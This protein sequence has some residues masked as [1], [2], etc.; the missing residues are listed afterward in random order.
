MSLQGKPGRA[1]VS[2]TTPS[3]AGTRK[4]S[5]RQSAPQATGVCTTL[6]ASSVSVPLSATT[7]SHLEANS[8]SVSATVECRPPLKE[9]TLGDRS[10]TCV[11]CIPITE[12]SQTS[13]QASTSAGKGFSLSW[14]S[15]ARAGS[16]NLWLPTETD[17]V[18]LHS[19]SSNG[20]F[21][22][23]VS[24]SWFSIEKWSRPET[25]SSQRICLQSSTFSIAESMEGEST[26]P[27]G[28]KERKR[29]NPLRKSSKPVANF[30][31]KV[32]LRPTPE[33]EQKLRQWFGCARSTYNWAL[34][35]IKKKPGEYKKTNLVWMK[36][37][38]TRKC[39]IPSN[40]K[41]LLECPTHVRDGAISDLVTAYNSN[42]AKKKNNSNHKFDMKF[43]SKKDDQCINLDLDDIKDFDPEA[44]TISMY[45]SYI[46]EAI[47]FHKK[48]QNG[49]PSNLKYDCKLVLNRLGRMH[50]IITSHI[51]NLTRE[52]QTGERKDK[53]CAIDPGVRTP[54]SIYSPEDGIAYRIGNKDIGRVQRMCV[55]LDK[56]LSKRMTYRVRKAVRRLR[57]RIKNVVTEVHCKTVRFL[58]SNFDN[59]VIPPFEVS[60]M[61]KK[62]A[63]KIRKKTVRQ[64]LSWRHYA[65]RLRLMQC[66]ER[67]GV[68][69]YVRGEEYTTKSCTSCFALK[70][71]IG[72]AK[73][74]KCD[75]CKVVIDRDLNGARNIFLKNVI[76]MPI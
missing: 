46:K 20:H 32:G 31:R 1:S 47:A 60:G 55:H 71:N 76:V 29:T 19:N 59:I 9:K 39:N 66:A 69:V 27:G 3:G 72:G 10:S 12:S 56:L 62:G 54:W 44:G 33:I 13:D 64:M 35:C 18:A 43:R 17:C 28:K 5:S 6:Q 26:H 50:L 41:Y 58:V 30:V 40:K 16:K 65:F 68:N 57:D 51:P 2:R 21:K 7:T 67:E 61:V 45:T 63:R 53:W 8:S 38:F 42:F 34:A 23:Q 25:Q 22:A 4:V 11:V 14:H 49:I 36:K 15:H 37:R 52:D 48:K 70:N 75:H 74:Y 73:T 24:N